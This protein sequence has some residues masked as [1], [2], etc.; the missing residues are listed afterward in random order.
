MSARHLL[1][2]YSKLTHLGWIVNGSFF[3]SQAVNQVVAF[4][5]LVAT[6]WTVGCKRPV[7]IARHANQVVELVLKRK[8]SC[9]TQKDKVS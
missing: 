2:W 8:K 4:D 1:L 7:L 3:D 5:I 9:A 6:V